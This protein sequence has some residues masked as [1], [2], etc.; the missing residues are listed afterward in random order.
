MAIDI[1]GRIRQILE[2]VESGGSGDVAAI[3]TAVDAIL[4]D[5]ETTLETK[6]DNLK[7][8]TDAILVDTET[9]LEDKLDAIK[10]VV[11]A[12]LVDTGTTLETK[13]DDIKTVVD[14]ILTDTETTLEAKLDTIDG[15]V[16][17]I[18][19][20]TSTTLEGKLDALAL[21]CTETRLAELDAGNIPT[22]LATITTYVD[23]LETSLGAFTAVENLKAILGNLS[24]TKNLGGI[25]GALTT[26]NNLLAVLGGYTAASPLKDAIDAIL[27]DTGTT[28][29]DKLDAI[30]ALVD[31]VEVKLD[32]PAAN[33]TANTR[34]GEVVGQK[35][36]AANETASQA[37]II[38]LLRAIITNYLANGTFGLSQLESLVDDLESR[39]GTPAAGTVAGDV[40]SIE[41][42]VGT[43]VDAAGTTTLFARLKQIVDTYLADGT[44]GLSNLK[45]LI[46]AVEAKLDALP[47]VIKEI[48][49]TVDN[50][51]P[52]ID[53]SLASEQTLFDDSDVDI[54][55]R[56][57]VGSIWIDMV[58]IDDDCTIKLY[59]KIDGTTYREVSS[60]SWATTD[61]D[62]VLLEGFVAYRDIKV[63]ITPGGAGAG[64]KAVPYTVV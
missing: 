39:L 13:L 49:E 10:A 11:D 37:S 63:T 34:I 19:V 27:L 58:N 31:A 9:T 38:G 3:K 20:D 15:I 46:D 33:E 28:L 18:L 1:P 40:E 57:R 47:S 43:N 7:T 41:T 24:T 23:T 4:V 53:T 51:G 26:T 55:A 21:V 62:G 50:T 6:L 60:H 22:D 2:L 29:E 59:H 36:D 5:T 56:C 52:N 30:D 16:D 64:N 25:L 12:V 14:S 48:T 8:V 45:T 61:A 44:I 54:T 32:L 35:G 42:K 17:A